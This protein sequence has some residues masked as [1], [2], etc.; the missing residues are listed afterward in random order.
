MTNCNNYQ[1]IFATR[2]LIRLQLKYIRT[3]H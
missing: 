2:Y 3:I 1:E